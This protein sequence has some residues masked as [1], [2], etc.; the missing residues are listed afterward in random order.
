MH[1]FVDPGLPI[2][3]LAKVSSTMFLRRLYFSKAKSVSESNAFLLEAFTS[4]IQAEAGGPVKKGGFPNFRM[5]ALVPAR[6]FDAI[7]SRNTVPSSI[8]GAGKPLLPGDVL[9]CIMAR[10]MF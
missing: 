10:R 7:V 3:S 8:S 1:F 6:Q 5:N 2:A 4:I 9:F